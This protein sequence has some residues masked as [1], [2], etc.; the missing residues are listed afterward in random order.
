MK[1]LISA[2]IVIIVIM[3]MFSACNTVEVSENSTDCLTYYATKNQSYALSSM[4]E[5]YNK[6][7]RNNGKPEYMISVIEFESENEMYTKMSTEM[8]AGKGPDMFSLDQNIPFEKLMKNNMFLDVNEVISTDASADK[9]D[10]SEYNEIVM[11]AG[12]SDGKR[13]IV[14]LFYGVN[15]MIADKEELQRFSIPTEQGYSLTY[16]NIPKDFYN[17]FQSDSEVLFMDYDEDIYYYNDYFKI[18]FLNLIESYIDYESKVTYFDSDSFSELLES[19]KNIKSRSG[20]AFV[21]LN[22]VEVRFNEML[23]PLNYRTGCFKDMVCHQNDNCVVM[24]GFTKEADDNPAHVQLGVAFNKNCKKYDKI[25]D[26]L[27]Y[28]LG[29]DAQERFCY[30][31]GHEIFGNISHPVRK[32]AFEKSIAAADNT[33]NDMGEVLGI[34]TE[35]MQ[36]YIDMSRNITGCTLTDNSFMSSNYYLNSVVG[37]ILSNFLHNEIS[38]DKFIQMLTSATQIYLYE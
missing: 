25:L 16:E 9:I 22:S 19:V 28:A 8:M 1:K 20:P 18:V 27:K 32:E 17:Y 14:P 35:F 21:E 37:D 34:D 24:K 31:K 33:E 10:F 30:A 29:E 23:F 26:F 13:Y 36:A 38:N 7:C 3:S 6:K 5:R 4:I 15:F 11:N 2:I 12:V